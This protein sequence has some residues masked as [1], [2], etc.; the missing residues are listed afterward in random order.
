EKKDAKSD[1]AAEKSSDAP[2]AKSDAADPKAAPPAA[3]PAATPAAP[4]AV[5]P[6]AKGAPATPAA[7]APKKPVEYQ[8]LAEVKDE[9]R[10]RLAEGKVADELSKLTGEIQ[11]Q[12]DSEFNKW[13]FSDTQLSDSEKKEL[14][15][16]PKSLTDFAAIAQKTGLKN[17]NTGPKS[18]LEL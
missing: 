16:P 4:P 8:P 15:P 3:A 17:G 7:E 12:L 10:R 9:I 1:K 13:R 11:N 6:D 14:P 5:A 18:L 2:A